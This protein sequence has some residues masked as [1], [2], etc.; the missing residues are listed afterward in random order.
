LTAGR[1]GT[2]P[3][4]GKVWNKSQQNRPMREAVDRAK[5]KP[6]I[7]FHGLRHTWASLAVMGGVPLIVVAKNLGHADSRM[8]ERF[9]GHLSETYVASEIRKRAPRFGV[10]ASRKVLA[11]RDNLRTQDIIKNRRYHLFQ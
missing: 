1:S 5:I 8:V 9:Y 11:I 7:S 2:D 3:I 6:R 10:K 4:F